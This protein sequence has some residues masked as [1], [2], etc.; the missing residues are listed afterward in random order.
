VSHVYPAGIA[1]AVLGCH[2]ER[3]LHDLAG[4]ALQGALQDAT[5]G[6]GN[7][8]VACDSGM[9]NGLL[10]GQISIPGHVIFSRIGIEGIAVYD[11]EN[12][13][14]SG[15]SRPAPSR[16]AACAQWPG[17]GAT[18]GAA[19]D[20]STRIAKVSA[21]DPRACTGRAAHLCT[22]SFPLQLRKCLARVLR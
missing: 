9:T 22:A 15:S 8:G 12:A 17:T 5:C 6:V 21:P 7:I 19:V 14:A 13:C 1:T 20:A 4:A 16:A 10:Q 2:I 11:V 3:S 18:S